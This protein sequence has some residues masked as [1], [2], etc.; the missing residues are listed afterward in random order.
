L[1]HFFTLANEFAAFVPSRTARTHCHISRFY[2]GN[3]C[4]VGLRE[5]GVPTENFIFRAS[6]GG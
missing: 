2:I 6:G 4:L 5:F 1:S 3:G